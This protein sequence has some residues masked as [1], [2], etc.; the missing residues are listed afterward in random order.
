MPQFLG[1]HDTNDIL[2][3]TSKPLDGDPWEAY[4]KSCVL[5]NCKPLHVHSNK[6][7]GKAFCVT[8]ASSAEEVRAAHEDINL[9]LQDL[10]EVEFSE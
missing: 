9:K 1:I 8:E 3:D 7:V 5:H 6:S 10:I 2:I 4:K